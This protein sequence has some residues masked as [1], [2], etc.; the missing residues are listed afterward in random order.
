MAPLYKL[1]Q[2]KQKWIW[3]EECDSG[4]QTCKEMLTRKAVLVHYDSNRP[5]KLVCDAYL[6]GPGLSFYMSLSMVSI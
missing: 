4:F 2:K 3:T 6:Y 5:I 1:V